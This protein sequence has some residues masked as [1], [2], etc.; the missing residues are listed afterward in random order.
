MLCFAD[1]VQGKLFLFVV[2]RDAIPDAPASAEPALRQ[3][4]EFAVA[5]W[6]AQGRAYVLAVKGGPESARKF[7]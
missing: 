6:T 4:G 5:S 7:L 1:T 3:V 2:N